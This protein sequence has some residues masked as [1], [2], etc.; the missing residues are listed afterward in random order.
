MLIG[1]MIDHFLS[2][3]GST[4]E[5]TFSFHFF[6]LLWVDVPLSTELEVATGECQIDESHG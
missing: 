6:D 5:V 2:R 1:I 4:P 3:R